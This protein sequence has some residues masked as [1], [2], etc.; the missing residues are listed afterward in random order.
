VPILLQRSKIQRPQKS[1]KCRF[2]KNFAAVMLSAADKNAGGRFAAKRSGPSRREAQV[3]SA[4]LGVFDQHPKNTFATKSAD[5]RN[6][7]CCL[8]RQ[9]EKPPPPKEERL[10]TGDHRQP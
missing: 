10:S 7:G 2:L 5:M 9:K 3:A 8:R 1:R 6:H 4:A